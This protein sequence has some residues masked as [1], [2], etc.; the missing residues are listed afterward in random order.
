VR[1]VI[2]IVVDQ[3]VPLGDETLLDF[4]EEVLEDIR[5]DLRLAEL[6][7]LV[8]LH[9]PRRAAAVRRFALHTGAPKPVLPAKGDDAC[10]RH[11]VEVD[12]EEGHGH[13]SRHPV[14]DVEDAH[15]DPHRAEGARQRRSEARE[16]F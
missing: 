9:A 11:N 6:E 12:A 4:G 2:A 15:R 1:E 10:V 7:R 8:H 14:R 13:G 3:V 16:T 5:W